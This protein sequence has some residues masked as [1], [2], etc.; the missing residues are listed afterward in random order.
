MKNKFSCIIT[1]NAWNFGDKLT[2][3][4]TKRGAASNYKTMSIEEIKSL[5]VGELA[6][7][8]GC[9]L[10][11]WCPSSFLKEGIEVMEHYGFKLKQTYVWVKVKNSPLT[12][13]KDDLT[14]YLKQ[15]V[16][17]KL[18]FKV[19]KNMFSDTISKYSLNDILSFYMG[20][21]FRS[22]HELCLIGINNNKFY[23]K[24]KNHSQRSVCIATNL[25]HSRK[26]DDLHKS[27]DIM[28]GNDA[29]KLELFARRQ[30]PGWKCLGDAID[31]SDIR[32]AIA[33]LL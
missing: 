4:A 21:A 18:E 31:G 28:L 15:V 30:Y 3:S 14:K 19:V 24:I 23:K 13:L 2:N 11:M 17:G 22:T 29:E 33:K 8:D 6:D 32:V 25:G 9:I 16:D 12:N 1:D 7:P 26:P 20:R 10:A 27:L 5:P